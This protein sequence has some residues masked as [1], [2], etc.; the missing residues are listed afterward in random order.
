MAPAY[1]DPRSHIIYDDAKSYFARSRERYDIIISE[2]SN[3]WVAG[4]ASL[5]TEEFYANV[6]PYLEDDGLFVQWVHTYE[7]DSR[8]LASI[9]L[10]ARTAFKDFAIYAANNSDLVLVARKTGALGRAG[11]TV[12]TFPAIARRLAEVGFRNAD[13]LERQRVIGRE[14]TNQIFFFDGIQANSDYYPFVDINAARARFK[15]QNADALSVLADAPVPMVEMLEKRA[16]ATRAPSSMQPRVAVRRMTQIAQAQATFEHITESSE[17]GGPGRVAARPSAHMGVVRMLFEDCARAERA[18]EVWDHVVALASE[19]NTT[20]APSQLD[21]L[22]QRFE[23]SPCL[24]KLPPHYTTWLALFR[25]VG[26]R[27]GARMAHLADQLLELADKSERQLDYL[28]VASATGHLA[29]GSR[30]G[31]LAVLKES[32]Q[33][34]PVSVL[35]QQWYRLLRQLAGIP[36]DAVRGNNS[37]HPPRAVQAGG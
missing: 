10:A 9:T 29:S 30:A 27:D 18:P 4:T 28:V 24:A 26:N 20:L 5:F 32:A 17:G 37:G 31:A 22:W 13:D 15:R 12:F 21:A 7:F 3:P 23:R 36:P 2:P 11:D 34:L 8:L 1:A 19:L 25:A 33:S 6:L 35:S 16:P 14:L